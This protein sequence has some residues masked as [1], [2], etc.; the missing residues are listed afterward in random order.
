MNPLAFMHNSRLFTLF[1]VWGVAMS[2]ASGFTCFIE[3]KRNEA[4]RINKHKK[5]L[6][7][8]VAADHIRNHGSI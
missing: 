4:S 6:L 5:M 2:D 8:S 7:G 1:F 3:A